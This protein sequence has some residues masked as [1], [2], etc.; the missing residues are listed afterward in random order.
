[1]KEDL[2][3]ISNTPKR[4]QPISTSA[5]ATTII[6]Y[7]RFKKQ[8]PVP[9]QKGDHNHAW[10]FGTDNAVCTKCGYAVSK[11]LPLPRS[12]FLAVTPIPPSKS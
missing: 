1:M 6:K 5:S 7:G 10:I 2:D 9:G 11:H 12:G 4:C 8:L 3:S